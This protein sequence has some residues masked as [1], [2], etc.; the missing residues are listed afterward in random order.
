MA[1]LERYMFEM[2]GCVS[3]IPR[4]ITADQSL[5]YSPYIAREL[6]LARRARTPRVLFV[7]DQVLNL[8]PDVFPASAVPFFHDAPETERSRHIEAIS[9]FRRSLASENGHSARSYVKNTA[10][11]I[12]GAGPI[13]RD[14]SSQIAAMLR[15][16]G[17]TTKVVSVSPSFEAAFDDIRTFEAMLDSELC[18]FVLGS[19]LSSADVMLSMAY[20]HTIPSVRLRYDPSSEDHSPE[21]SGAVK[22][23]QLSE[24]KTSFEALLSN[25]LSVF[26]FATGTE[27]IQTL[28]TPQQVSEQLGGWDPADGIGIVVH[29]IPDDSYVQDRVDGVLRMTTA[30]DSPRVRSDVICGTLYDR[31]KRDHFYYTYEPVL[32]DPRVQKIRTPKEIN[33]LNCGTCIDFACLFAAML[34]AA[35]E[36]A[37]VVVITTENS[38][39]AVA[40][41]VTADAVLGS[42]E[43]TLGDLRGSMNRGEIVLFETTGAVE[44]RGQIVGAETVDERK[45]GGNM[46][47]YRTAKLA[48]GRLINRS[49]VVLKHFVEVSKARRKLS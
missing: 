43:M 13:I 27:S 7:D 45:E 21:L 33:A 16:E 37:V 38:A 18:V 9:L 48:A 17:F 25:Y 31:V 12:A 44:A 49:D 15:S 1:K 26:A 36:T 23:K 41:Y 28:A 30:A 20:A 46:L 32:S 19:E 5:T 14:A 3:I 24:L 47:D 40:G 6:M 29:V 42:S 35:H 34:E 39:H 11:V 8:Y 4:R 2:N 22:W 10:T